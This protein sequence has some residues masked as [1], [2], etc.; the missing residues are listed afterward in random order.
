MKHA[1]AK[2]DR[3]NSKTIMA[4]GFFVAEPS[5]GEWLFVCKDAPDLPGDY[6]IKVADIFKSPAAFVD[7]IAHLNEKTW[8]DPNKFADFF[9]R[10]RKAN[11][12][13][14]PF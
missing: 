3:T 13:Y 14:G 4:D 8:F 11:N 5:T 7:W 12:L 2:C 1:T 6:C 9:T 10:L